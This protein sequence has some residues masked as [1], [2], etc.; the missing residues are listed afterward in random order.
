M[1]D[2]VWTTGENNLSILIKVYEGPQYFVRNI[3]VVGAEVFTP[4][5]VREHLGFHKGDVYDMVRL[6]LNLRG[7]TP[8]FTDVSSLYY[9]RGYI[10]KYHERRDRWCRMRQDSVDLLDSCCR[11]VKSIISGTSIS[12]TGQHKDERLCDP[13]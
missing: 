4:D 12:C 13:P 8:D 2:S 11:K 9:D 7:P 6:D 5:E 1:S 3:A 10:G